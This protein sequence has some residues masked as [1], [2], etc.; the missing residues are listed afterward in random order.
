MHESM[1]ESNMLASIFLFCFGG[2]FLFFALFLTK[3]VFVAVAV[4]LQKTDTSVANVFQ[5]LN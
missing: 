5:C 4:N 2:S 1:A 3:L